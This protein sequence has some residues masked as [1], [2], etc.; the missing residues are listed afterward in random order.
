MPHSALSIARCALW[1]ALKES[2]CPA[3]Q[4]LLYCGQ[5]K[6]T[7]LTDGFRKRIFGWFSLVWAQ[8]SPAQLAGL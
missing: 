1:E 3:S 4:R 8:K 5:Q 2:I 6:T 7:V